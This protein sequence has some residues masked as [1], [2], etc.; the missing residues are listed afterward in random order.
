MAFFSGADLTCGDLTCVDLTCGE[1]RRHR[2]IR[3]RQGGGVSG[4]L[5]VWLGGGAFHK[6]LP[7]AEL[8][9]P[10]DGRAVEPVQSH[11]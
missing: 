4:F 6:M 11:L 9:L 3:G 1:A 7:F 5:P 8:E 2:R 10:L